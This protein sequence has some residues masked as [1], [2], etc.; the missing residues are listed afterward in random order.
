MRSGSWLGGSLLGTIGLLVAV[1][2]SG[3]E[4]DMAASS[5]GAVAYRTFAT[6]AGEFGV[7]L[8]DRAN[9]CSHRHG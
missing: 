1:S 4:N 2:S 7:A 8:L 9:R 3:T 5:G 6:T